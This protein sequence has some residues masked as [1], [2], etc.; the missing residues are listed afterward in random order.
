MKSRSMQTNIIYLFFI[1]A[2]LA[3]SFTI[4]YIAYTYHQQLKQDIQGALE[5]MLQDIR[6]DHQQEKMRNPEVERFANQLRE[7]SF[8]Y[9]FD[10]LALEQTQELIEPE[11][12]R[13]YTHTQL[14]DGSY[15]YLSCST[16][17]L[18]EQVRAFVM[19][20]LFIFLLIF[21]LLMVS[22]IVY[23]KR[24]FKYLHCLVDFCES[25]K[26]DKSVLPACDDTYEV[27]SLRNAIV[28]LIDMNDYLCD[29]KQEL[30]KEAAHELKAPIAV[31]KARLSLFEKDD[32]MDK[33]Q[34]VFEAQED[35][36]HISSKLKELL[37]L[38]SIEWDMQMP[39]AYVNMEDN[40]KMMQ[41]AFEPILRKKRVKVD[42]Q[43]EDSFIIHTYKE[44]M[45]KVL[46]AVFE[47]IFIHT[48]TDSTIYVKARPNEIAIQNEIG[49]KGDVPLFS[50]YI[51]IKMIERLSDKL[52][53]E[54]HVSSDEHYFYTRLI[55]HSM[56]ADR[57][58]L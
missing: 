18:Q 7:G 41:D 50:S 44:A 39:L 40:C 38:K 17:L 6:Q 57:C 12:D 47:N 30:F 2:F 13:I 43:W 42:S 5:I 9:L 19:K 34:L 37:F 36:A 51:G 31:L 25:Y 22:V 56:D 28:S 10:G 14:D 24:S 45:Q 52:G 35:I 23:V 8:A 26:E 48:R 58:Q 29:Q 4:A 49:D 27:K 11:E 16:S 21:I 46:Q 54:Y 55:F 3:M 15:L 20:S 32:K 53:Y 33:K 1:S